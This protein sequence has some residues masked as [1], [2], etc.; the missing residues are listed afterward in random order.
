MTE[1]E[2]VFASGSEMGPWNFLVKKVK[3]Y[4]E[5]VSG[6]WLISGLYLCLCSS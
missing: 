4:E 6:V 1:L 5:E 3:V 2:Y